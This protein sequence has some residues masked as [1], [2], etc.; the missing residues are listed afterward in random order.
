MSSAS[1]SSSRAAAAAGALGGGAG[2]PGDASPGTALGRAVES[3]VAGAVGSGTGGGAVGEPGFGSGGSTSAM[4]RALASVATTPAT[5]NAEAL[6]LT[7][8]DGRR[9]DAG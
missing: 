3:G 7:A 8:G 1:I 5:A 6:V 4:A 2:E 9:R